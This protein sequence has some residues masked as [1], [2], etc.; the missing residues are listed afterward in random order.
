MTRAGEDP[1]Q[2]L[3]SG[4]THCAS[5]PP[6]RETVRRL[7][8]WRVCCF[9]EA[10]C[11]GGMLTTRRVPGRSERRVRNCQWTVRPVRN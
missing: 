4:S 3:A 1:A 7:F 8:R 5:H 2:L 10:P 11:C 9:G 6:H